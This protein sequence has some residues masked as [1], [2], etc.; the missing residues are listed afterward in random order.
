[1]IWWPN[2][3]QPYTE[4]FKGLFHFQ[5]MHVLRRRKSEYLFLFTSTYHYDI[6]V[7]TRWIKTKAVKSVNFY[8]FLIKHCF[9]HIIISEGKF[10]I[11]KGF[12]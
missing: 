7:S 9:P 4:V 11:N 8:L 2:L 10:I 6:I 1:M 5:L 3:T 12:H